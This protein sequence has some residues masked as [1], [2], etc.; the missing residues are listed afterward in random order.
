MEVC[1]LSVDG[2]IFHMKNSAIC[3]LNVSDNFLKEDNL[4]NLDSHCLKCLLREREIQNGQ[5]NTTFYELP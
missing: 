2:V 5:A 4:S 3:K 1:S